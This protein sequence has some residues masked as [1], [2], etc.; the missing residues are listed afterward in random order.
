M[1]GVTFQWVYQSG[2]EW[3][4]FDAR[5]NLAV[6][7]MFAKSAQGQVFVNGFWAYINPGDLFMVYNSMRLYM[8]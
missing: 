1:R 4:P 6:E 5:S 3:M 8:P 7:I 2:T